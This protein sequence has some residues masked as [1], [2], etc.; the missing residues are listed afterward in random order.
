LEQIKCTFHPEYIVLVWFCGFYAAQFV[1][2]FTQCHTLHLITSANRTVGLWHEYQNDHDQKHK[3][4]SYRDTT[5][6]SLL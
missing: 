5:T 4:A 1:Q 3:L 6:V 2:L